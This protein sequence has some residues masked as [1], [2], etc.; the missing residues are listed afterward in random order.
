[1]KTIKSSFES[2]LEEVEGVH[3]RFKVQENSYYLIAGGQTKEGNW[4][5]FSYEL[6]N[7]VTL[8]KIVRSL[9]A[10]VCFIES[11][12]KEWLREMPHQHH[13]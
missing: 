3:I 2:L 10:M 11:E 1:M 8:N 6:K 4:L 13:A 5:E 9:S 12:N 7:R